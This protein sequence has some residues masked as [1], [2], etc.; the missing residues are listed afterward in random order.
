MWNRNE[1]SIHIVKY[2]DAL[3]GLVAVDFV[4]KC[5][6]KARRPSTRPSRL[7]AGKRKRFVFFFFEK[8]RRR[9]FVGRGR[10][11]HI[12]L[13]AMRSLFRLSV[14]L[15]VL[16]IVWGAGYGNIAPQYVSDE[17]EQVH[18]IHACRQQF[19]P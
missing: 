14:L 10:E 2:N 16:V 15:C 3:Q 11:N 18:H 4:A 12:Q 7:R 6:L 9:S 19:L 1:I 5:N 17:V 8:N 13:L